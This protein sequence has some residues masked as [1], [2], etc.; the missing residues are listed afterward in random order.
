MKLIIDSDLFK[1]E[2]PLDRR[3]TIL[4]GDS[5]TGKST[6]VDL[7]SGVIPDVH[8]NCPLETIVTTVDTWVA[9]MQSAYDSLLIFDDLEI[10]SSLKFARFLKQTSENGNYFLIV[11]REDISLQELEFKHLSYSVF[12]MWELK[13]DGVMHK[14]VPMFKDRICCT[15]DY[16]LVLTEDSSGGFQF[17]SQLFDCKVLSTSAGKNS[18]SNDLFQLVLNN[19]YGYKKILVLFDSA[20]FGCHVTDF[21]ETVNYLDNLD[22]E[23]YYCFGYESF[24][25]LLLK[26]NLFAGNSKVQEHFGNL[27]RYANK[28]MS[29]E[30]YFEELLEDVTVT[31]PFKYV[32]SRSLK[33]C[34]YKNCRDSEYFNKFKCEKCIGFTEQPKFEF[35]LKGTE[36]E[37]FLQK[38][39]KN[40]SIT[41]LNAF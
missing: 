34:Y 5:G 24:E 1:C 27:S 17:F 2:I 6:I 25:Y 30:T 18:I 15:P 20:A 13:A 19:L 7:V 38:R 11:G 36:F 33:D 8:I 9:V 14:A 26:T 10:V 31:L 29:W 39:I 22:V 3:I 32:H 23:I 21:L 40:D 35:L 37:A 12:S 4:R 28:Y 16:D 41:S